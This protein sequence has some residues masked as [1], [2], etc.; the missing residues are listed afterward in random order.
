M[1]EGVLA[2]DRDE[3]ILTVNEAAVALL[4]LPAAPSRGRSL[5]EAVRNT[6]LQRLVT[7]VLEKERP[8]E[9][10]ITF[11]VQGEERFF[12]VHA[13]ALYD[14][15]NR[16]IG[17]V[18]V[19]NDV[20]RLRRL[21][22]V[23]RDFVANVSH[24]LRTPIATLRGFIETLLDGAVREPENA[25]RFLR[26]VMKHVDRLNTLI[27]DLLLLAQVEKGPEPGTVERMN[28]PVRDLLEAV[29]RV[30]QPKAD[31]KHISVHVE[32]PADLQVAGD[33]HLLEQALINL[34]DNAINYSDTG[35]AVRVAAS[36]DAGELRIDVA[37]QGCGIASQHLDRVFERF[38]RVDKGRSRDQ[39]GT[40]LGLSIVK[41]IVQAHRGRVTV[42]SELGKGSTFTIRLP[43]APA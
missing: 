18:V 26:I 38:Y 42:A 28:V 15:Q 13:T 21:E 39:G 12:Q 14:G 11:I 36:Q 43:L 20:T 40:G 24:E 3:R 10:E 6:A 5:L 34:L 31:A 23:R 27:N 2:V 25:E 1:V 29:R 9:D 16:R 30:C 33:P 35:R 4:G 17:A 7:E 19:L 32:C 22:G 41:H 37:D 8:R